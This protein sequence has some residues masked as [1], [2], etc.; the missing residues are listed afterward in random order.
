MLPMEC[1]ESHHFPSVKNSKLPDA[2]SFIVM[3]MFAE[4]GKTGRNDH[5][6]TDR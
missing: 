3:V 2:A 6:M 1:A 5:T 4:C